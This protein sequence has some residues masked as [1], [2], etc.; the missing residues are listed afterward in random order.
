MLWQHCRRVRR[1]LKFHRTVGRSASLEELF[2]GQERTYRRPR[3]KVRGEKE[4][5]PERK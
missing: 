3:T 1:T 4:R 5:G 2:Q